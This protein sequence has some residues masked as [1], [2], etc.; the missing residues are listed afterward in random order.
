[1]PSLKA[2]LVRGLL[3]AAGAGSRLLGYPITYAA[4]G[5]I[6]IHN[7]DFITEPRFARAYGLGAATGHA[8]GDLHI[9]WRVYVACWAAQQAARLPGDFVECGTNT[10]IY[11]RAILDYVDFPKLGKTFYLLDTFA[12]IPDSQVTAAERAAKGDYNAAYFDCWDLVQRTFGSFECVRLVKGMVPDTLP[13]I[14]SERVAFASIDM[15]VAKPEID[16]IEYLWDRLVPGAIVL[17]DDYG[18]P[19][20]EA[21]KSAWDTFAAAHDRQV[22]GIPTGQGLLVK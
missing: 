6:S 18:W 13:E 2:S 12:G 17:I 1:V 3:R 10:G 9:E 4:D 22:L 15:N 16:A 7:A 8:Y 20:H 19:R 21:Q 5:L 14:R 11:A